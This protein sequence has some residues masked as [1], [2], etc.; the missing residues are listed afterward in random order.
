MLFGVVWFGLLVGA[1][2]AGSWGLA[3]LFG[4][5]GA[6]GALQAGVAWRS[7]R[8]RMNQP[9]AA[10]I[11]LVLPCAATFNN[12]VLALSIVVAVI[13][14]AAVASRYDAALQNRVDAALRDASAAISRQMG[15]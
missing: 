14:V 11:A 13:A 12:R 1:S 5:L 15:G 6:L 10:L 4:L 3:L 7:A 8:A 9:L 2:L